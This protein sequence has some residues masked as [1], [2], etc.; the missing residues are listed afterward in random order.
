MKI[1][2][3]EFPDDLFYVLRDPG[4]IWIKRKSENII[5]LGID[6]YASKRAGKI[7]FVRTIK[8]GQRVKKNQ[9]IGTY[10]SGKWVGQIRAP[11]AGE[12]IEKNE[13]LRKTPDF[14]NTDPYGEGWILSIEGKDIENKLVEDKEIVPTGDKL[15]KYIRW[16]ISEE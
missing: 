10:E 15:E 11:I 14:I 6:D 12:I 7:E 4:H 5:Q 16:R 3:Y 8:E 1:E 13:Q 2:Q 9:I